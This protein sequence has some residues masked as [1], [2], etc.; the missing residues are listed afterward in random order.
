[1]AVVELIKIE[2]LSKAFGNKVILDN[3]SLNV[4]QGENLVVFGQSGTGKSVL[5][6]CIIGLLKPDSGNILIKGKSVVN[7]SNKDLNEI[8]KNTGFL[9]QGAALYDSM[10]VR[11]NLEFPL[12]RHSKISDDEAYEKVVNTLDLVSLK[13]AVDKMPSELSGGMKKRIG[14]ARSIITDPEI[15]F[16]DEPTTGLDPISSK[17]ISELILDLQKKLKM[18][19]IIVTHDLNCAHIIS[20]RNIFLKDGK[21]AYKGKIEELS[22]SDDKFLKNFF[23]NEIIH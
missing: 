20:D 19:S 12:K 6:K 21:I 23:S 4:Y 7:I 9:F 15:M 14:L 3:I 5:L 13:D 8:R 11:E 18:T 10:T 1:M 22:K 17:E 2:N 16:Y